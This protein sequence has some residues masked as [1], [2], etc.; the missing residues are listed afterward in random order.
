MA[1]IILKKDRERSLSRKHPWVFSGAIERISGDPLSGETVTVRSYTGEFLASAA[2]SPI[3]QIRARVWTFDEKEQVDAEFLERRIV[4]ALSTRAAIGYLP[5]IPGQFDALR[6]IHG[7]SDRLP[8]LVVDRYGDTLVMQV[9]SAGAEAW[10]PTLVDLLTRL[11]GCSNVYERSDADVREYEGL[12]SVTGVLAGSPGK[13]VEVAEDGIRFM[14]DFAQGHKTGF[15][16]DQRQNRR[17]V[18]QLARGRDVLN[19]FCYTGG[20]SFYAA[21]EGAKSVLSL[22]SSEVSLRVAKQ[23]QELNGLGDA[24]L[25]W[26]EADVFTALRK[27]RDERRS[28]DLIIL[29]PPKFAAT[30]SQVERA[31]RAYKDINLLAFKL[32]RQGGILATFSCSGGIDAGLFQKIVA[33]AAVD[34]NVDAQILQHLFQSPDHPVSIHFPEGA[35]LK[36]LILLKK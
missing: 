21:R 28:F 4:A 9:L 27:F 13:E 35:Y 33:G 22:D 16:L 32:L 8:G 29:D 12:A 7:E 6:L 23:N 15:Y 31:S 20:F 24:P 19:C 5:L 26:R 2:Y 10:K 11:T 3:S 1:E 30:V 25:E 36:G 17:L 34:A 14:V 18:G